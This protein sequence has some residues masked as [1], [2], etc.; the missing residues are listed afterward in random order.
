MKD[1]FDPNNHVGSVYFVRNNKGEVYAKTDSDDPAVQKVIE[2][3]I[4]NGLA[5]KLSGKG[6]VKIPAK[7]ARFINP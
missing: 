3:F 6:K 5:P 4:K 7:S 2:Y 1:S